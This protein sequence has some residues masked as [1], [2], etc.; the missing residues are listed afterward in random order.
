MNVYISLKE[1]KV[2]L[3]LSHKLIMIQFAFFIKNI[4]WV[5]S[6]ETCWD[7]SGF[8]IIFIVA[9]WKLCV[10]DL[11]VKFFWFFKHK[12]II[13]FNGRQNFLLFPHE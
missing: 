5:P 7:P 8:K 9:K 13:V 11:N 6:S 2:F 4:W 12:Y 3:S 10:N 1:G